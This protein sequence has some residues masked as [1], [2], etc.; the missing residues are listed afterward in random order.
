MQLLKLVYTGNQHLDRKQMGL[1]KASSKWK[2]LE[3]HAMPGNV[4]FF[5]SSF[6]TNI[7]KSPS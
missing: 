2:Q 4:R 5:S 6:I 1:V 3:S 7:L